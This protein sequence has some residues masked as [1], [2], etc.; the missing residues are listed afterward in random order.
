MSEKNQE[1]EI[2]KHFNKSLHNL[3][4]RHGQKLQY[5]RDRRLCVVLYK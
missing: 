2:I 1:N 3:N 5:S 4:L